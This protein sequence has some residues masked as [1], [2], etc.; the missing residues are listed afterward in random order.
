M[1][2]VSNAG[3]T[4]SRA[5]GSSVALVATNG[6]STGAVNHCLAIG[7]VSSL[8]VRC[9][10][11]RT[12]TAVRSVAIT[13]PRVGPCSVARRAARRSRP[14]RRD[15]HVAEAVETLAGR[16]HVLAGLIAQAG[17]L[18]LWRLRSSTHFA[19]RSSCDGSRL[20]LP[21]PGITGCD[22][23][24]E[25]RSHGQPEK[26]ACARSSSGSR[27]RSAGPA[28]GISTS[29]TVPLPVRLSI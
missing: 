12:A 29:M 8:L 5:A 28:I 3:G 25:L 11:R 13:G 19:P 23:A 24:G 4:H 9:L 6:T 15:V 7:Q 16:D 14:A 10:Q 22:I 27:F 17:P 2:A 18:C 21:K 20:G 1:L 26:L